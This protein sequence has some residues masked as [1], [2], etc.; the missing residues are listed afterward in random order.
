MSPFHITRLQTPESFRVFI[1][2][3]NRKCVIMI[4][5]RDCPPCNKAWPLYEKVSLEFTEIGVPPFIFAVYEIDK[6][7]K[8]FVRDLEIKAIPT[9]DVYDQG[10]RVF[11]A[12]SPRVLMKDTEGNLS[13]NLTAFL[14]CFD[15]RD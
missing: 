9:F 10:Q 14:K 6:N 1:A 15:S 11:R 13:V 2:Q 8:A 4:K 3:P 5:S 7:D 12:S